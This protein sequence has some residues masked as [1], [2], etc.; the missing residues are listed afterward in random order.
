MALG[1]RK[2]LSELV[3]SGN[4]VTR[5]MSSWLVSLCS[6]H[7]RFCETCAQTPP[8]HEDNCLVT[9]DLGVRIIDSV[10][11]TYNA[12]SYKCCLLANEMVLLHQDFFFAKPRYDHF[13]P[14]C[15][16]KNRDSS[17]DTYMKHL[18][19]KHHVNTK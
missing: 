17:L 6:L 19:D 4:R 14:N 2:W 8:S 7:K 16:F 15:N 10:Q 18:N 9:I 11:S 1:S 12:T 3:C 13:D 5:S